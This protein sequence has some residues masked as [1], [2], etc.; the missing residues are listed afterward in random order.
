MVK[1]LKFWLLETTAKRTETKTLF[2]ESNWPRN[3]T[4]RPEAKGARQ[5][6]NQPFQNWTTTSKEPRISDAPTPLARIIVQVF[7]GLLPDGPPPLK[8]PRYLRKEDAVINTVS[9]S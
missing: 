5:K 4:H 8:K 6:E 7:I 1:G 3:I 2:K 9:G